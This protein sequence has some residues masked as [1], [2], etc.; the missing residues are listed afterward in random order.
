MIY[1]M[2]KTMHEVQN[3]FPRFHAY[4]LA[5]TQADWTLVKSTIVFL[6]HFNNCRGTG[7]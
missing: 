6:G 2:V 5:S 3:C 7:T 4:D 1:A